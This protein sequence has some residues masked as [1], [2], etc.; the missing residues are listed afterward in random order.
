MAASEG[1]QVVI[2]QC[3]AGTF[4]VLSVLCTNSQC[5][6][7]GWC[8]TAPGTKVNASVTQLHH[9]IAEIEMY[10]RAVHKIL[11]S[12]ELLWMLLRKAR[13]KG[14]TAE[15]WKV[16]FVSRPCR[17][18]VVQ[19]L[20]QLDAFSHWQTPVWWR[21]DHIA[22]AVKYTAGF[23]P[24]GRPRCLKET[25]AFN[26][27]FMWRLTVETST[28]Q[29]H[30]KG[31]GDAISI[32]TLPWHGDVTVHWENDHLILFFPETFCTLLC[33]TIF[34]LTLL[35]SVL[36]LSPSYFLPP[37]SGYCLIKVISPS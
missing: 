20:V 33:H 10:G 27:C 3:W 19:S 37:S 29:A 12:V 1:Q 22:T 28:H 9:V 34:Y 6:A 21:Q 31:K 8:L 7:C 36:S 4:Y 14:E 5:W 26:V 25:A 17:H 24:K 15:C 32:N 35:C 16:V 2:T 11:L 23:T 18:T 30:L 13:E